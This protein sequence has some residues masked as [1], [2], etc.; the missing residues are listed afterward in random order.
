MKTLNIGRLNK[1]VT[2]MQLAEL[3]DEMGQ[4]TQQ[5]VPA[6][7]VWAS[8]YPVRGAEFCELQKLQSRVTH[9]CYIRYIDGI[10]AGW[11]VKH[12]GK[13]YEIT[14]AIDAGG[15][16]KMLEIYCQLYTG[17]EDYNER[18]GD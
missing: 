13:V 11:L 7:T 6:K 2:L 12:A 18:H 8:L 15:E 5:L 10:D 9:K 17:K 16:H 1:R 3:P 4:L 14:S